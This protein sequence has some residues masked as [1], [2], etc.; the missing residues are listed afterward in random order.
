MSIDEG[1]WRF[2]VVADDVIPVMGGI[3]LQTTVDPRSVGFRV[4]CSQRI[5]TLILFFTLGI[6]TLSYSTGDLGPIQKSVDLAH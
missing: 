1:D 4:S 2:V 5:D 6:V 3:G